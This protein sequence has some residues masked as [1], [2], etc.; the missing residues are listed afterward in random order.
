[1]NA[2]RF[3]ARSV[4]PRATNR[5]CILGLRSRCH[6]LRSIA[7]GGPKSTCFQCLNERV[8][9]AGANL[10]S[11]AFIC[12]P[13]AVAVHLRSLRPACTTCGFAVER[14]RIAMVILFGKVSGLTRALRIHKLPPRSMLRSWQRTQSF[15]GTPLGHCVS[16]VR[17][18]HAGR[19]VAGHDCSFAEFRS[20]VSYRT[21]RG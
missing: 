6:A 4:A 1:M 8:N 10:R 12:G 19:G 9:G 18:R 3:L 15:G 17:H 20:T 5:D 21:M 14:S 13:F 11:S 7:S 2:D 16:V